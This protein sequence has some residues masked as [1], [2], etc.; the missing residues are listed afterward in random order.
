MQ[1]GREGGE[2]IN[3]SMDAGEGSCSKIQSD[4]NASTRRTFDFCLHHTAC[5]REWSARAFRR[6]AW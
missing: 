2:K 1:G 6:A 3:W 4:S 5:L